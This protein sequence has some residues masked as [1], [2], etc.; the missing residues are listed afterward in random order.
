MP[1]GQSHQLVS[2]CWPYFAAVACQPIHEDWFEFGEKTRTRDSSHAGAARSNT[3]PLRFARRTSAGTSN[4]GGQ[5]APDLIAFPG[6]AWTGNAECCP[7]R[8]QDTRRF[9]RLLV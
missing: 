5:I 2:F 6:N 3:M 8:P 1:P 9:V 7:D 4:I